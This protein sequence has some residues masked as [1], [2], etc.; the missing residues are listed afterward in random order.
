[1]VEISEKR[2]KNI[3]IYILKK[4]NIVFN[5]AILNDWVWFYYLYERRKEMKSG[6]VKKSLLFSCGGAGGALCYVLLSQMTFAMTESF[7]LSAFAVG[8]VFLISRI[9]DG[10]T[11]F[12]AGNIVDRTH[13]KWG[14]ARIYDLFMVAAWICLVFCFS[15]PRGLS[16]TAKLI[17][18]FVMYNLYTSVFNTFYACAD[19]VRLKRSLDEKGRVSA[20]SVSGSI[21]T[22]LSIVAGV[23][24]P[25]M[26]AIF[27]GQPN[28]WTIISLIFA[29]PGC[30][31]VIIR[32][33]FL[34]ESYEEESNDAKEEKV[35]PLEALKLVCKNKYT[36][37][38]MLLTLLRGVIATVTANAGTYYFV[39]VFGDISKAAIPGMFAVINV[40]AVSLIPV[41]V[42]RLGNAK[43]IIY[44]YVLAITFFLLRYLMPTNLVWYTFCSI[45]TGMGQLAGSYLPAV[46]LIDSMDYGKW[47]DGKTSEGVYSAVRSIADKVGLG[48]GSAIL[49]FI[50]EMGALPEGGYSIDSVKF[51]NNGFPIVGFALCII[52]MMFY[53]LDKKLPQIKKELAE[54]GN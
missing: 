5:K 53:N 12:I 24:L 43:T 22:L 45:M 52:I 50:L 4:K 13:T 28:G 33:L 48:L 2:Y 38:V 51:L 18:L 10:F 49:G 14:K 7:G 32:F 9:F 31:F 11:D 46:L 30:L 36:I 25:I 3:I 35:G 8:M 54:R 20:V 29:I 37:I 16:D 44:S 42:K 47:K 6:N 34:P 17:W 21:T 41:L 26:I 40:F 27:G 19:T 15:I 1:M 23:S 39:Y